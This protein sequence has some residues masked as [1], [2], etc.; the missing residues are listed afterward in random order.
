MKFWKWCRASSNKAAYSDD[1]DDIPVPSK[2]AKSRG[3]VGSSSTLTANSIPTPPA[4]KSQPLELP[5]PEEPKPERV[6]ELFN[7]YADEEEKD[8]ISAGGLE[9][10]YGDADIALDGAM[11]WIM[12]WRFGAEEMLNF[13]REEW[14][15]G[16]E[17]LT[18]VLLLHCS[19]TVAV[20]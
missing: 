9:S 5:E 13:T 2:R 10:L 15:R 18:F 11:P 19:Y 16:M 17:S 1:D 7:K 12:A 3:K 14:K 20:C 8:A 4:A 6:E